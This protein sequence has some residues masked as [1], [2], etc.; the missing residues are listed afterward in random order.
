MLLF[1][2]GIILASCANPPQQEADYEQTKQMMVDILKTDEGK[3]AL[4]EIISDDKIK[5]HLIIEDESVKE[6]ISDT[7]VSEKG[8]DMWKQLFADPKFLS[9]FQESIV[10]E[11]EKMFKHLMN[12]AEFQKQM[13]ELLQNPEMQEQ[14]IKLLK[15]QQF[16]EYLENTIAETIDNPL[17]RAKLKKELEKDSSD[18][19]KDQGAKKEDD[20]K[21]EKKE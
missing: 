18:S 4:I 8:K 15:S 3:K 11:Q 9:T 6:T 20:E 21:E 10:E 7:L 17:Y 2:C 12:D 14:T 1:I 13:L 16:R 19:K 5:Q